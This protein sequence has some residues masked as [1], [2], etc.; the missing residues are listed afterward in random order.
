MLCIFFCLLCVVDVNSGFPNF[1]WGWQ[2][3]VMWKAMEIMM[4]LTFLLTAWRKW[5]RHAKW[6]GHAFKARSWWP[7]DKRLGWPVACFAECSLTDQS[8]V[9]PFAPSVSWGVLWALT[10][11]SPVLFGLNGRNRMSCVWTVSPVLAVPSSSGCKLLLRTTAGD[12]H[13]PRKP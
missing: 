10:L 5:L 6:I 4:F 1:L 3:S 12:G 2:T 13:V 8:R 7:M 9:C 11:T